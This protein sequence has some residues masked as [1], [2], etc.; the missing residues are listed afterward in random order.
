VRSVTSDGV[1]RAAQRHLHP[2][3]LRIVVV[4][5]PAVVSASVEAVTG[6]AAEIVTGEGGEVSA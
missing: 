1:L 3:Q 4:G 6:V 2:E 5:D